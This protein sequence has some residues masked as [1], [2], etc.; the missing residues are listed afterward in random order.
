MIESFSPKGKAVMAVRRMM[1]KRWCS[2]PN[3][4][5]F[6]KSSFAIHYSP[7]AIPPIFVRY[8]P[9]TVHKFNI[10]LVI[11]PSIFAVRRSPFAISAI[12]IRRSIRHLSFSVCHSQFTDCHFH[13]VIAIHPLTITIKHLT[14]VN[15]CFLFAVCHS[16]F[17]HFSPFAF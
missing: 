17:V 8:L 1:R 10:L 11:F 14:F 4:F 7:F 16:L 9:F 5:H 12:S 3:I 2:R 15:L 13:S 6:K